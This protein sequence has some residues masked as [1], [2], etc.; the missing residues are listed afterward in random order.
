M[1]KNSSLATT[2]VG[3]GVGFAASRARVSAARSSSLNMPMIILPSRFEGASAET[4]HYLGP[5]GLDRF[6]QYRVRDQAVVSVAEYPIDGL[7][8]LLG[9][10]GPQH[11][12]DGA[13][14]GIAQ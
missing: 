9:F 1:G 4:R 2:W 14:I 3:T 7:A 6:H 11:R 10:H 5:E 8:F 12:I 13:D